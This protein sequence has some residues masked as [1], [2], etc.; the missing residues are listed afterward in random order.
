MGVTAAF[1]RQRFCLSL[2]VCYG[3][4]H[5][6]VIKQ[7]AP[8]RREYWPCQARNGST[9]DAFAL[10]AVLS[11]D[12]CSGGLTSLKILKDRAKIQNG[13]SKSPSNL[14]FELQKCS[15]SRTSAAAL[16]LVTCTAYT[17]GMMHFWR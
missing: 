10:S 7:L 14:K 2:P 5:R 12:V 13:M 6:K 8:V 9:L 1:D 16:A 11:G 17:N 3:V 4:W 15:V